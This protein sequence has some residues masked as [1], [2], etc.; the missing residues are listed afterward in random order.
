MWGAACEEGNVTTGGAGSAYRPPVT[1]RR[2]SQ[3]NPANTKATSAS[4]GLTNA[5]C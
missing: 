2:A 4:P 3:A 1:R 5:R